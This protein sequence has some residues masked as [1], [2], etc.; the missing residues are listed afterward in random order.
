MPIKVRG[1]PFID[2]EMND[3]IKVE[4]GT[5]PTAS[6]AVRP[7]DIQPA[8]IK[9]HFSTGFNVPAQTL[10][11]TR[12]ASA[13]NS[14]VS[15][16]HSKMDIVRP[17]S[18]PKYHDTHS[19]QPKKF[20]YGSIQ[21]PR[22]PYQEGNAKSHGPTIA[23]KSQY[24]GIKSTSTIATLNDLTIYP[25]TYTCLPTDIYFSTTSVPQYFKDGRSLQSTYNLLYKK[26]LIPTS[27]PPILVDSN[28]SPWTVV[29]GN[30][31]LLLFDLLYEKRIIDKIPI[32]LCK[33]NYSLRSYAKRPALTYCDEI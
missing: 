24:G 2:S 13:Y 1:R 23:T 14:Y 22:S 3:I 18:L 31:R 26:Q 5:K 16:R 11:I 29:D 9:R 19:G 12:P 8:N 17:K 21:S 28:H 27:L 30:R 15:T 4:I 33:G 32:K 7:V 20:S 25:K 6:K 10:A